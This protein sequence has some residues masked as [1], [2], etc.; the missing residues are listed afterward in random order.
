MDSL[1]DNMT[2]EMRPTTSL[3]STEAAKAIARLLIDLVECGERQTKED[4]AE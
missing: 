4:Q 3:I 1:Q 2:I